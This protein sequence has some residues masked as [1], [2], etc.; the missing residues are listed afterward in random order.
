MVLM[1]VAW[2][3]VGVAEVA[4]R[5]PAAD[6][7]Q[8]SQGRAFAAARGVFLV[9]LGL[10]GVALVGGPHAGWSTSIPAPEGPAGVLGVLLWGLAACAVVK[11]GF[12]WLVALSGGPRRRELNALDRHWVLCVRS[13][14]LLAA[15]I[16]GVMALVGRGAWGAL[17]SGFAVSLAFD[18]IWGLLN[19]WQQV[20][21]MTSSQR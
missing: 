12:D 15:I 5:W 11:D 13:L 20:N 3:V 16:L 8:R 7:V 14:E 17:V 9:G 10:G 19:S 1:V 21:G 4:W 2:M 18:L 6:S